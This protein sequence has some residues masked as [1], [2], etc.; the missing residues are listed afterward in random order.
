MGLQP[1]STP[2]IPSPSPPSST[3]CSVQGLAVSISLCICQVLT[4]PLRRQLYQGPVSKHFLAS[5]I[6]Y[7]FGGCIWDGSPGKAVSG[8]SSI[9]ALLN[10]LNPYFLMWIFC[11]PF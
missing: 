6:V 1:P 4:Q 11:S 8:W 5:T 7:W 9:Q 10:T 2:S 3:Q